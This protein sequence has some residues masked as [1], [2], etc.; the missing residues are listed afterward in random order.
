VGRGI[1]IDTLN[2]LDWIFLRNKAEAKP[3][4]YLRNNAEAAPAVYFKNYN[5]LLNDNNF[6]VN[7]PVAVSFVENVM[8]AKIDF[9]NQAGKNYTI[10][11]Y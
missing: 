2:E 6:V 1:F 11:T 4:F 9:Y 10:I 5:E 3:P 7:V 8:R